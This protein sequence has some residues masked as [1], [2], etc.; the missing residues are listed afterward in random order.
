MTLDEKLILLSGQGFEGRG[1]PRLGIPDLE[2]TDGPNGVRWGKTATAFPV[3]ISMAAAWDPALIEQTGKMLAKEVLGKGRQVLLAPCVNISRIPQNGRNFEC[4]G[5][6]P[7]LAARTAVAYIKGVQ[8]GGVIATVKHFAANNQEHRRREIDARVSKRALHEIYFPAFEASVK[9][10]DVYTVMAAYNRLNGLYSTENPYLLQDVLKKRWGFKGFVMSDWD[11]V[12]HTL[13]PVLA[14]LDTEMPRGNFTGEDKLKPLVEAGKIPM[15]LIDDKV[16]RILWVMFSAGVFD[17]KD[18]ENPS[19]VGTKEAKAVALDLA[20]A[21]IVLMK[22]RG[23]ILPIVPDGR[24]KKMAVIGPGAI[25]PRYG[26][27]GSGAVRAKDP[28]LPLD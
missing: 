28:A 12:Q 19:M 23:N 15:E 1:I 21:S 16:R 18:T 2:M 25:F 3:G 26:G 8:S 13:P 5:E 20:R 14:G 17:R 4:F 27:G 22:N 9:E 6:D 24:I 11:A 10:A 7:H